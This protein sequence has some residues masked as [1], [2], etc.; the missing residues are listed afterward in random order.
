MSEARKIEL[1]DGTVVWARVSAFDGPGGPGS[2]APGPGGPGHGGP[3]PDRPSEVGA[4]ERAA[5]AAEAA[6]DAA[7]ESLQGMAETIKGVAASVH[8]ATEHLAPDEIGVEFGLELSGSPGHL[9]AMLASGEARMTF[10]VS[11]K[12]CPGASARHAATAATAAAPTAAVPP[13]RP[14]PTPALD[15]PAAPAAP[16]GPRGQAE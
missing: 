13:A 2:G 5:R 8:A 16:D 7:A 4:R 10:K 3:G 12:W 9:V 1:P 15:G 14:A 6:A 11:L